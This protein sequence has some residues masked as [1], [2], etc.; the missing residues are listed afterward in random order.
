MNLEGRSHVIEKC[1]NEFP[2]ASQKNT[3]VDFNSERRFTKK[4]ANRAKHAAI[5]C[6][7]EALILS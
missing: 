1:V 2:E 5:V 3:S 4:K 7:K 6:I